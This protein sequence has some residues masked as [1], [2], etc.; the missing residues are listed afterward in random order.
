MKNDNLPGQGFFSRCFSGIENILMRTGL[1]TVKLMAAVMLG[2]FAGVRFILSEIADLFKWILNVIRW[3]I[4]EA[5]ESV[6]QRN[7]KNKELQKAARKAKALGRK[8]YLTAVAEFLGSYLF[9][10]GGVLYT[11][12]NYVFP[13]VCFAFLVG[14]IR[15]GAGLRYGITV[16]YNGRDIGVIA[17]QSDYDTAEHEVRQ[18][19]SWADDSEDIDLS[20]KFS[21]EMI[22]ESDRVL[23]ARQ[24]ADRMLEASDEELTEAYGIY[25]DGDFIGAVKDAQPVQDA[26]HE[27]LLNYHVEGNVKDISY[28]SKIEYTNGIYLVNSVKSE[29]DT[30][31]MLTSAK[32]KKGVYVAQS[33]DT[34]VSV[35]QKY[36][37][38][39]DDFSKL[40]PNADD[41]IYPGQVLNVYERESYLPI[42]YEL[43]A[44]VLS[45]LDYETIEVETSSLNVGTRALLVKG[46]R[47]E[48][49]SDIEITFVDGIERSRQTI[50]SE[51]T[52]EP[53][54]EQ[55]GIGTYA[56]KPESSSTVL[57]GSGQFGWP[58]DGGYISDTFISNRNHKGLDIAAPN[59]TNIYAGGDGIVIAAGWNSGGYGYFVEIDHL[60]GYQT[61]YAHMSSVFAVEGQ[62]VTRGQLIGA[63]GTTGNS[64]GY[65]C[66]FEV[67]YQGVC[68]NPANFLNTVDLVYDDDDDDESA[69]D[70]DE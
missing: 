61:V 70:G 57:T 60:N 52:K 63:V 68:L 44:Q 30:I 28:S 24:L 39:D 21:L 22:S 55:I 48:K 2:I 42:Q 37:M 41:E 49:R 64:S 26:L 33:G 38:T 17:Q 18:R 16:E 58:V 45:F 15:Y 14:V 34:T 47:G 8:E 4:R 1:N 43:E 32:T 53:V 9:G 51:I 25:I 19:I 7:K 50:A 5:T 23:N 13:V 59:G 67:R 6:R 62:E 46:E 31:N 27:N 35:C 65:H 54:V 10:E 56:A 11:A 20:A 12:F 36:S 69:A 29:E 40:N 66:H 3:M